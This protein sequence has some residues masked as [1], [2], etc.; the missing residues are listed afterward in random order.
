MD[1]LFFKLVRVV[2]LTA[3]PFH[4]HAKPPSISRSAPVTKPLPARQVGHHAATSSAWPWRGS[5]IRPCS[6]WRNRYSA[7]FM[8]VSIGPGCTLLTVM[9]RGPR[10]RAM[11]FTRPV[12][13]DLLIAYTA[14]PAKG[15]RRRWCC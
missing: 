13:A 15:M 7:G 11:P 14:P 9:P 6:A 1:P 5:A 10:S 12:R 2:N 3:R 8:S 4:E